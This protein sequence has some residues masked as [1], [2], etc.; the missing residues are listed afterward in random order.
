MLG[1]REPCAGIFDAGKWLAVSRDQSPEC[2]VAAD[3]I[4]HITGRLVGA[5]QGYSSESNLVPVLPQRIDMP[6][7][8]E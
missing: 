6:A 4:D 1:A 3:L 7:S 8:P 5:F 2:V